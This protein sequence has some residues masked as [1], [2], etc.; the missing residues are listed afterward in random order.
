MTWNRAI[1]MPCSA[2]CIPNFVRSRI[3][4]RWR[5][6]TRW[7]GEAS[8]STTLGGYLGNGEVIWLLAKLPENIK[9]TRDDVVEP[10]MLLTNSHDGTIAIDF[11]LTTVRVV[12]QN[13]LTLAMRGDKSSHVFKRAHRIR[14]K[15]LQ[16]EAE[17][18]YQVC[19]KAAADLGTKFHAMHGFP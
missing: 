17:G 9:I 6:S 1:P 15:T 12:C 16:R 10:Y 8:G 7:W 5:C 4:R 14:P 3:E 19:T 13:T 11:R 2:S 18:F